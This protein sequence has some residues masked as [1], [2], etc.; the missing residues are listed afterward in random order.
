[1]SAM[2]LALLCIAFCF[3]VALQAQQLFDVPVRI[4]MGGPET[5]DS[6][7]R[8]W[9]GDGPGAGDPLDI[10]PNDAGAANF[11]ESWCFPDTSLDDL[12]FD[13]TH[14]GDAAIF[15]TI[16]WDPGAD[17]NDYHLEIP[18]SDG[19]YLL[20][21]YFQECCCT[22][23]AFTIEVEGEIVDEEVTYLDYNPD[24]PGIGV[25]GVL[26]FPEIE[27]ADGAMSVILRGCPV[28]DC[29]T[30]GDVNPILDAL[31]ILSDE[32]CDHNGLDVNCTFDADTGEAN[33]TWN[34]V[35]GADA[36]RII[37]N[38][39]VIDTVADGTESLID[40]DPASDGIRA[41]YRVEALDG[42]GVLAS[43]A[44]EI[45][46]FS[47]PK[48][49]VCAV[50]EG[51]RE[52]AL[53]WSRGAGVAIDGFRIERNGQFLAEVDADTNT[54]ED[55]PTER[56]NEYIVTPLG[57]DADSCGPMVCS[58][59][60]NQ[61]FEIPLRINMG[62][63]T[64]TDS[65]GRTWIGDEFGPGDALAIRPNDL[66]GTNTI[67]NWCPPKSPATIERFGFDPADP[68]DVEILT[69]IRWDAGAD[70]DNYVLEFFIPNGEYIIN[71][72]F[73]E[74]C[75]PQRHFKIGLQGEVVAED[76]H[77][78]LYDEDPHANGTL[79]R[80]SFT[81]IFV[82][83]E[84]L[85]VELLPCAE[86]PGA[87]DI[88]AILSAIEVVSS[89]CSDPD[90]RVC[91][92]NLACSVDG[93]TVT[94]TWTGP[95]CLDLDGYDV[96]KNGEKLFTLPATATS[97]EDDLT[98]TRTG[99]YEVQPITPEGVDPCPTMTC[100]AVNPTQPFSIP[101][102]I[103]MG[104][105]TAVDS[106]GNTWIGDGSGPAD[107]LDIRIDDLGGTNTITQFCAPSG[108]DALASLGFD[109][110]NS[111]DVSIFHSIRWDLGDDDGDFLVGEDADEDG[112]DT[113]Y[114][115]SIPVP[116]GT[117]TVNLYFTECVN[118]MR[119]F[120]LL[121]QGELVE[122]EVNQPLYAPGGLGQVGRLSYTD[123]SV[124]GGVLDIELLP[125]PLDCLDALDFNAILSALEILPNDTVVQSCPRDLV[126][127]EDAPG[128]FSFSWS[129]GEGINLT[130]YDVYRN[131]E[132]IDTIPG[133]STTFEDEPEECKRSMTYEIVPK[134][135]D[136]L[137]CGSDY[138]M[139][140]S[141]TSADCPFDIPIRI[142]MG[143]ETTVDSN[144]NTWIG[145][146]ACGDPQDVDGLGI[147][148]DPL[149]GTNSICN[150]C[151]PEAQSITDMGFDGDHPG[152]RHIFSTIRWDLGG[153]PT[154]FYVDLPVLD[155]VYTVNLYFNECCCIG[156]AFK[157]DIE[158]EIVDEEV[159]YLD[160]HPEPALGK[161][162]VLTF[163][164]IVVDD[165]VLSIGFLPCL[166]CVGAND[167]NAIINAIEVLT[168]GERPEA[169]TGL[170]ATLDGTTANLSWTPPA[171]GIPV[172]GYNVYQVSPGARRRVNPIP[173]P[174]TQL[175]VAGLD[176]TVQ[177]CFVVRSVSEGGTESSDSLEDCVGGND[178]GPLFRRGDVDVNGALEITDPINN[179]SFQFLGTFI[180]QCMDALDFDDN[181]AVEI[182][183]PIANLSHQFLGT[184][185][186]APPG[187]EN[188][189]VD[190]T[191]D[192]PDVGDLGC[193][194]PPTN[195]QL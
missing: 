63:P 17:A 33:L 55:E 135:D 102:R 61:P 116:N 193:E 185:P 44:C 158:G 94:G 111:S 76:V 31:E 145:E 12:G 120:L 190:P 67:A 153:D 32:G 40:D 42:D 155:D 144:G 183:D 119:S 28:V 133:D 109:A 93:D 27:V 87:T 177:N 189:G 175:S 74:C 68:A 22:N 178:P 143:G 19:Q 81:E 8:T 92:E 69:T 7:G 118:S 80:M 25:V 103:N 167:P 173:I 24:F 187:S 165:G 125:C 106:Q 59:S 79:G 56:N 146:R 124:T 86:C 2:R 41:E 168:V 1:M 180:P 163:E 99:I 30:G 140:C 10:R 192:H 164:D 129:E 97:F 117:Y 154:D 47:C 89:D 54:F 171:N 182:T 137:I 96:F 110:A 100:S 5:V 136:D 16:R 128:V 18:I 62:G 72:Y 174:L 156:R 132:L 21:L 64:L 20:N 139:T 191:E 95:Q 142:N 46:A 49:L 112:G 151:A 134:S 71:M 34:T 166:D 101:T 85:R 77:S 162:G 130:G 75:C 181:G 195:C 184:T 122:E 50:A 6:H 98:D 194:N 141:V 107:I 43:C 78:E 138:R 148:R 39:T 84:V 37:K 91:P 4:N 15:S 131:G 114:R 70:T 159:T 11:I 48:D 170:T 188:C 53:S 115:L 13:T 104:G 152:D 82:D 36:Y 65:Q 172:T 38:G 186:A 14:P 29:P 157:I 123:I 121:L 26:S 9:L 113:D 45:S 58:A 60:V 108:P 73:F 126:C 176:P 51:S 88:N 3:P 127:N 160:Y 35:V 149:G 83:D 90:F 23:R 105:P 169:P 66:G 161:A 147:R 179:L 52:V 57:D 150:W